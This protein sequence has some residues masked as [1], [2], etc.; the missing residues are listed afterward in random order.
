LSTQAHERGR[1]G[2]L[3]RYRAPGHPELVE[4]QQNLAVA[5]ISDCIKETLAK[6]PPLALEQRAKLAEL[7]KPVRRGGSATGDA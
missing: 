7:L 5:R 2:A 6:A 4:A 3:S 1:V